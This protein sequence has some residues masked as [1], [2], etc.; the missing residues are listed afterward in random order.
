MLALETIELT[1][2]YRLGFWRNRVKRALDRLNLRVEA[3][4]V[5]GLL[6]PNGAGKTSTLKLLFRLIF[7]TSGSAR[8]LGKQLDD[9]SVRSRVA[10]LPENPAFYEHLTAQEFLNYVASLFG[11]SAAERRRLGELIDQLGL[12]ASRNVPLR[13]FSKGMIQRLGITQALINDPDVLFLDEPMSGLD[14]LGR[15]EVREVILRLKERQKTVFFSTHILADAETLCDR[16]AVLHHGRLQGCGEL[17][18]ILGLGVSTTEFVL[19]GPSAEVMTELTAYASSV[20]RTGERVRLEIP[21]ESKV[22]GA[23]EIILRRRTKLISV[24][25]VKRSLEDYFLQKVGASDASQETASVYD[26]S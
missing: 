23:L 13:R 4:E 3:G 15:R 18:T 16:V 17:N 7:P 14:P 10:Y 22:Q 12:F 11:L 8:I 2:D 26:W 5:F 21:E 9:I 24:N 19:E 1:K 25:P 20:I 6:G